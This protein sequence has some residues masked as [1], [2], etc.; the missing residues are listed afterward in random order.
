MIFPER[1]PFDTVDVPS[2]HPDYCT[3]C[4]YL[5]DDHYDD[6]ADI[7]CPSEAEVREKWGK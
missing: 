2:E 4:G 7:V 5:L 6:G 3:E 1:F